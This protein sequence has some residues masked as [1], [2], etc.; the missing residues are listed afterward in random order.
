MLGFDA[1]G[2]L[3]LRRCVQGFVDNF[4]MAKEKMQQ[5]GQAAAQ[6]GYEAVQSLQETATR[7]GLKVQ[8]KA[9][10][11]VVPE[12][13]TSLNS[14]M[15]DLGQLTVSNVFQLAGGQVVQRR[16]RRPGE[17]E[18][19][20]DLS[21]AVQVGG[22]GF[23]VSGLVGALVWGVTLCVFGEGGG[24]GGV[25][26]AGLLVCV[27]AF[28]TVNALEMSVLLWIRDVYQ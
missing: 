14:L 11:I 27:C 12:K 23:C 28:A 13:S 1:S 20:A 7:L 26:G 16:A 4:Q 24:G 6:A 21:Q 15:L 17:H 25:K 9:P 8:M 5:A 22:S 18:G 10:V 2:T 19:R 3:T